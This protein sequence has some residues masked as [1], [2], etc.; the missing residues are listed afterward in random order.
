VDPVTIKT[1]IASGE[2]MTHELAGPGEPHT[3]LINDTDDLAD[4]AARAMDKAYTADILG[5]NVFLGEDGVVYTVVIEAEVAPISLGWLREILDEDPDEKLHDL[6]D[7][8]RA[9][10]ELHILKR[11]PATKL[12]C[13]NCGNKNPEAFRYCEHIENW[14]RV[15]SIDE[16]GGVTINGHYST[17]EGYDDG[18]DPYFECHAEVTND[19]G[20]TVTCLT[21]IP[22]GNINIIDF[23]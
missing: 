8:T 13:P 23:V 15:C 14:R 2:F 9:A 3:L 16:N 20:Q 4:Q 18:N 7:E 1:I 12:V 11:T 19:Q 21:T 22:V 17:G 6:D 10:C 5:T